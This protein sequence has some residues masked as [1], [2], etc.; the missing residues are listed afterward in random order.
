MTRLRT[1]HRKGGGSAGGPKKQTISAWSHRSM[2]PSGLSGRN[3]NTTYPTSQFEDFRRRYSEVHGRNSRDGPEKCI[4]QEIPIVIPLTR[5]SLPLLPSKGRV[6][7]CST[8]G[9]SEEQKHSHSN[10]ILVIRKWIWCLL[11]VIRV[12]PAA[13]L[14]GEVIFP[15]SPTLLGPTVFRREH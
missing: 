9:R 7:V 5:D 15:R 8:R 14:H 10:E 12:V 13:V 11:W 6:W 3:L 4:I 1:I 2:D